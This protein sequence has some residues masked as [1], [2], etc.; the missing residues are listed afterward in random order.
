LIGYRCYYRDVIYYLSLILCVLAPLREIINFEV[1]IMNK[2][3]LIIFVKTPIPGQVKTRLQPH[4]TENQSAE[5][6]CSF[7][8]DL[9]KKFK[10]ADDFD[11]WYAVSPEKFNE[12]ILAAFVQM[13]HY[14][15]QEGQDL[16]ERMQHAFQILFEKGYER[17]VLI[18]S[19]IPSITTD[20]I[21]QAF[22]SLQTNDCII[23]P[24]KDGGYYL[25]ALS[26][27]H[28]E[29]FDDL[30]WSTSD[31]MKKTIDIL[32]KNGLTYKLLAEFEDIDTYEDLLAFYR[33]LKNKS[34]DDIDFPNNSWKI[35]NKIFAPKPRPSEAV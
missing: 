19:D 22:Q 21:S 2:N 13:D 30:P 27:L 16:G 35:L 28:A 23:G 4:L 5:L 17:L 34:K 12:D 29:I 10:T 31:V 24:S 26:H 3:A 9:D 14:F 11:T 15:L 25:I 33:D 7:L 8:R 18:G 32:K 1:Y 20:I 6:Y